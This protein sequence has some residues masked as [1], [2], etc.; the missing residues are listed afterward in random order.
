MDLQSILA[1]LKSIDYFQQPDKRL[2][3]AAF[4][5]RA[6]KVSKIAI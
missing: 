5:Q 3:S 2:A 1:E 6:V 4:C